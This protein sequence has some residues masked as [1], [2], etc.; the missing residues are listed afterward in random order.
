M[1]V[2]YR[3]FLILVAC[4]AVLLGIQIPNFV[5]QYDKRV[6]AH[7]LEVEGNLRGYQEIANR[8]YDGSISALIKKHETS[9]DRVSREEARPIRLM[10]ERYLRFS[11]EQRGLDAGLARQ[12][13]FIA[14]RGD[15]VLIHE[16][17]VNYSFTLPLN[18]EAVSA[19]AVSAVFVLMV[20]ELSMMAFS[21]LFRFR[22]KRSVFRS[23]QRW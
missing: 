9:E 4:T 1:K 19:G 2:L 14:L 22:R 20:I 8:H 21:R 11:D 5:D 18:R 10:F 12:V 23:E 13:A 6:D 17:Y 16:T 3:Y 7:L 15:R